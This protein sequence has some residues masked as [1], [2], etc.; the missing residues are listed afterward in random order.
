MS[1]L[2]LD[3]MDVKQLENL[4]T[5][6]QETLKVVRDKEE[7]KRKEEEEKSWIYVETPNVETTVGWGQNRVRRVH[8]KT[9]RVEY[10][11]LSH[12]YPCYGYSDFTGTIQQLANAIKTARNCE[13]SKANTL[14]ILDLLLALAK[15]DAL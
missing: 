6:T 13:G 15:E 14:I 3:G 8:K 4:L 9:K 1:D 7:Q 12:R 10:K 2:T 11:D 5:R